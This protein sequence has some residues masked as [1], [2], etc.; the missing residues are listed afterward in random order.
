[1]LDE[2]FKIT[3]PFMSPLGLANGKNARTQWNVPRMLTSN[4]VHQSSPSASAIVVGLLRKPAL[5]TRISRGPTWDE[6]DEKADERAEGESVDP[7]A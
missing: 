7:V 2:T 6:K 5:R 1:M 4:V 3:G